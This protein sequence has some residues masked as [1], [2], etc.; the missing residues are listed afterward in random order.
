MRL[1]SALAC[2]GASVLVASTGMASPATATAWGIEL[3]GRYLFTSNGEWAKTNDYFH[4]EK[5]VRA[6]WTV[7]SVCPSPT[8]CTGHVVSSEGWEADGFYSED[9]W[10]VRRTVPGWMPCYDG[11]VADGH[12]EYRFWPVDANG[13]RYTT[14]ASTFGGIDETKGASGSC[15]RNLP[16]TITIPMRL[17]RIIE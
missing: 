10:V 14:D 3:N 2:A 11:T 13:Q 4:D 12:Q 1:I 16:L 5:V 6:V 7:T 8:K 9:R 17:Q 15:G